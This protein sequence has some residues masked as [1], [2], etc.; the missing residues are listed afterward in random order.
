MR[1]S[2]NSLGCEAIALWGNLGGDRTLQ[3][4]S[5]TPHQSVNYLPPLV[6]V[7]SSLFQ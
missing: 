2:P 6:T 7:E 3:T 4:S 5:K 1:R